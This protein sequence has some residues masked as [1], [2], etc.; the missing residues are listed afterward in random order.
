MN[1]NERFESLLS[2]S[3]KAELHHISGEIQKFLSSTLEKSLKAQKCERFCNYHCSFDCPNFQVDEFEEYWDLP[4]SEA[5]I[6]RIKCSKCQYYDPRC[7]CNDCYLQ[8][9]KECPEYGGGKES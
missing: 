2:E 4:A 6:E 9:S 7:T 5:G 3:E 1:R 8:G